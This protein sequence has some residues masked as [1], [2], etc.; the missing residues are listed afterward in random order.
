MKSIDKN[1]FTASLQGKKILFLIGLH[2]SGTSVTHSVLKSHPQ[3]SGFSGTG[4][5]KDEGQHLQSVYPAAWVHGGPGKFGFDAAAYFDESSD[6]ITNENREKIMSEWAKHWD[7]SASLLVEK[8]PPHLIRTRFLQAI[9]PTASFCVILRHP[10]IVALATQKWSETS[11][12]KLI[13][14][15]LL[16]HEALSRDRQRLNRCLTFSYENMINNEAEVFANIFNFVDLPAIPIKG[17]KDNNAKYLC[18]WKLRYPA[19]FYSKMHS[20]L[21]EK[22]EKRIKK[23]GYSLKDLDCFPETKIN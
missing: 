8:S 1:Q 17:I 13:E 5:P 19:F 2:R 10:L 23:F 15:W 11:I 12:E 4:V 20:R 7:L 9:F 3:I 16:C 14:H 22:Y 21:L 6:L 18:K